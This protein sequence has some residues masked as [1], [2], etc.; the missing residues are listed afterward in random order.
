MKP[1]TIIVDVPEV[2]VFVGM[3]DGAINSFSLLQP[4]RN[5]EY[6]YK[7]SETNT[8]LSGHTKAITCLTFSIDDTIL[9]SGSADE[10]IRLWHVSSKQLVRTIRM[11]GVI[12]N[13]LVR[14]LPESL[15]A[16][17]LQ[18]TTIIKSFQKRYDDSQDT[19]MLE[20]MCPVDNYVEKFQDAKSDHVEDVSVLN[21]KIDELRRINRDLYNFAKDKIL[22]SDGNNETASCAQK[23][24]LTKSKVRSSTLEDNGNTREN[25]NVKHKKIKL[26]KK[27]SNKS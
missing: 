5:L 16:Y 25:V 8:I 9:V 27:R 20:I 23:K 14:M 21:E 2:R 19:Q 15:Q 22:A 17:E 24:K 1:T 3:F 6:H 12:S 11:K 10:T 4:P 7:E 26:A 13:L 18:S